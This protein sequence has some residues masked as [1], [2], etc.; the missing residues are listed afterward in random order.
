MTKEGKTH[1]WMWRGLRDPAA[2]LSLILGGRRAPT[3]EGPSAFLPMEVSRL[4][5]SHR[6]VR[7]DLAKLL[8]RVETDLVNMGQSD[9]L[10]RIS[11][12]SSKA[13]CPMTNNG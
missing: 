5:A 9:L 3:P 2:A 10:A 12:R 13:W 11:T 7:T 8:S 1:L 4:P 6:H